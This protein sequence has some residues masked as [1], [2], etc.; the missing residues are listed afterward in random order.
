MI[1]GTAVGDASLAQA[2]IGT[3]QIDYTQALGSTSTVS[4]S[5]EI[6]FYGVMDGLDGKLYANSVQTFER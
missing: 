4:F 2:T 1:G 3:A 6:A 5:N